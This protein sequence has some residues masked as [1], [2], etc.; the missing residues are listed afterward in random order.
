MLIVQKFSK[1]QDEKRKKSLLRKVSYFRTNIN[2]VVRL[3][4]KKK[5]YENEILN[6]FL[7]NLT[8]LL[9]QLVTT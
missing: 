1:K 8:L 4:N 3:P 7:N 6:I 9:S 2:A 5:V